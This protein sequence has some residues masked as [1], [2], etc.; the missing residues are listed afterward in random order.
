MLGDRLWTIDSLR[1]GRQ[2]AAHHRWASVGDDGLLDLVGDSRTSF[3]TASAIG[4]FLAA[5]ITTGPGAVDPGPVVGLDLPLAGDVAYRR[6]CT[7]DHSTS[8]L[9]VDLEERLGR[10]ARPLLVPDLGCHRL[11]ERQR[12]G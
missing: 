4:R 7:G 3:G 11:P 5:P 2:L 12:T 1:H 10:D 8:I 6:P 9:Q